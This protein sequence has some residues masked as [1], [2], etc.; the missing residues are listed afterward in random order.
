ML[1]IVFRPRRWPEYFQI[2]LL[3]AQITEEEGAA[4]GLEGFE[5]SRRIVPLMHTLISQNCLNSVKT[6]CPQSRFQSGEQVI[7]LNPFK[8]YSST[9]S[10]C[11]DEQEE[12][13]E[14]F[15][16]SLVD[17]DDRHRRKVQAHLSEEEQQAIVRHMALG[18]REPR[19]EAEAFYK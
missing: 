19:S 13:K 8:S 15:K 10:C 2:S 4:L 14:D 9:H 12:E 17:A 3:D 18:K 16:S 11:G 7:I 1:L 6:S 5:R